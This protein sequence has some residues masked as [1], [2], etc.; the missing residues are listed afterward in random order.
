MVNNQQPSQGQMAR[1]LGITR[2]Y[3]N[4]ILNGRSVPSIRL[5][6]AIEKYTKGRYRARKFRPELAEFVK[7]AKRLGL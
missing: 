1:D 5:A 3:L 4:G 2:Q 6:I 7:T